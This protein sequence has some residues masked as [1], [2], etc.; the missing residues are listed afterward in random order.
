MSEEKSSPDWYPEWKHEAF[1]QLM[2]K[3]E[4]LKRDYGTSTWPRWDYDVDAGTLVFSKD[5]EPKVVAEIQIVGTTG[6]KDWLWGLANEHWPNHVVEDMEKVHE[7][8]QENAIEELTTNYLE[9]EDL[10]NLGWN[11]TAVAVRVLNAVGAYRP[12]P[13]EGK[14]GTV[15]FLIKSIR[16]VS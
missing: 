12:Q 3:Q 1:H 2:D 4:V 9:D 15:F 14:T 16:H 13:D 5:G 10:N 11:M 7:F 8:G 6:S